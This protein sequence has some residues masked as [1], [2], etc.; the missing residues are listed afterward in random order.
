[1][2]K[3]TLK[4]FNLLLEFATDTAERD[5]PYTDDPCLDVHIFELGHGMCDGCKARRV[6]EELKKL[7]EMI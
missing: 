2:K 6:L 4:A 3:N 5:C 7:K 1:M